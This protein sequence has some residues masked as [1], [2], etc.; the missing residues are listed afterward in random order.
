MVMRGILL[1]RKVAMPPAKLKQKD[2]SQTLDPPGH[3]EKPGLGREVG[4][5]DNQRLCF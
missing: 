3:R 4:E 2:T 5:T 1:W